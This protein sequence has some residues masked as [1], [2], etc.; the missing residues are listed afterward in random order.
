[1][2]VWPVF[3][4]NVQFVGNKQ[5]LLFVDQANDL[6]CLEKIKTL[7]CDCHGGLMRSLE[8]RDILILHKFLSQLKI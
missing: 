3:W 1:M 2:Y 5:D 7:N 6:L 8:S 4:G